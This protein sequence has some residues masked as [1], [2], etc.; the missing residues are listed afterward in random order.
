MHKRLLFKNRHII[1]SN[2]FLLL[3]FAA[4]QLNWHNRPLNKKREKISYISS[5]HPLRQ[6]IAAATHHFSAGR[7]Q[8][9]IEGVLAACRLAAARELF[10]AMLIRM[11]WKVSGTLSRRSRCL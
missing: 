2:R 7:R 10:A 8:Y 5:Q 1:V 9:I 6:P 11:C 4:Q 3:P